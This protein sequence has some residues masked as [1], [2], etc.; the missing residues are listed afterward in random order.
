MGSSEDASFDFHDKSDQYFYAAAFL[1]EYKHEW[2][3]VARGNVAALEFDL[4]WQPASAITISSISLPAFVTALNLVRES[5]KAWD[6]VPNGE[7]N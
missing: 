2:Q 1:T 7:V 6:V 4:L 5:L 3:Q